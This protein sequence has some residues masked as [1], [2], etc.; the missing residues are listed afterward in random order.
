MKS[1]ILTFVLSI[2]AG[3]GFVCIANITHKSLKK[4][5]QI[6]SILPKPWTIVRSQG[7]MLV[8]IPSNNISNMLE[9]LSENKLECW[10]AYA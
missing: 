6:L 7:K 10:S 3:S 2:N 5:I 1:L 8:Y 4:Q 9:I